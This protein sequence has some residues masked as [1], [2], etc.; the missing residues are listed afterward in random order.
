MEREGLG[1]RNPNHLQRVS[2]ESPELPKTMRFYH[3]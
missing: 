1:A 2:V 3:L